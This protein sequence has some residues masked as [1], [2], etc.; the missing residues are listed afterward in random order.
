MGFYS[1]GTNL[2]TV[3]H[4]ALPPNSLDDPISPTKLT[5][6]ALTGDVR[7]IHGDLVP[8]DDSTPL[9][10]LLYPVKDN[11]TG[12]T[13]PNVRLSSYSVFD[14]FLLNKGKEPVYSLNHYNYDAQADLLLP[15]AVA[16]TA[17]LI[18]YFFRGNM[19]I[20]LPEEGIYG[21][22]DHGNFAPPNKTDPIQDFKGFNKIKLKL[23]NT[24]GFTDGLGTPHYQDAMGEGVLVASIWFYRNKDYT[25]NLDGELPAGATEADYLA[26]RTTEMEV[27]T[28]D[29]LDLNSLAFGEEAE[30]TFN[31]SPDP[32]TGLPRELPINAWEPK[33]FVTFRGKFGDEADAVVVS[34]KQISSPVFFTVFNRIDLLSYFGTCYTEDQINA[35]LALWSS[36]RA[37]CNT[38]SSVYGTLAGACKN[39][40]INAWVFFGDL[41]Q[42]IGDGMVRVHWWAAPNMHT[43]TTG[44]W[45]FEG[46]LLTPNFGRL[47]FLVDDKKTSLITD[48]YN[49]D[50]GGLASTRNNLPLKGNSSAADRYKTID[51]ENKVTEKYFRFNNY[52]GVK[53]YDGAYY[54]LNANPSG[55][56]DSYP[57]S[58]GC[59]NGYLGGTADPALPNF[60]GDQERYPVPATTITGW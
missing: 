10:L 24:S 17:G 44:L 50:L 42:S 31:F 18:D 2:N 9:A 7:D 26:K 54:V 38:L 59:P 11:L 39:L 6:S 35:D 43:F 56:S 27:V 48:A 19:E 12:E 13:A 47:A 3:T 52:R 51:Y 28:S 34:E 41:D 37:E 33:L 49:W 46:G 57:P 58:I 23:K 32:S 21:L 8:I 29:P 36:L 22:V 15:R 20:S 16:Y 14:K 60:V 53:F 30:F 1:A 5:L 40:G 45:W 25:D 55:I 4:H